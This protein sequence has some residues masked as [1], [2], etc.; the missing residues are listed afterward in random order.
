MFNI[1]SG[2]SLMARDGPERSLTQTSANE[3]TTLNNGVPPSGGSVFTWAPPHSVPVAKDPV[4]STQEKKAPIGITVGDSCEIQTKTVI[5]K[6]D[7]SVKNTSERQEEATTALHVSKKQ[8]GCYY[9]PAE[10]TTS[11]KVEISGEKYFQ[12]SSFGN[13]Q[14]NAN[15]RRSDSDDATI[16]SDFGEKRTKTK[17]VQ[18]TLCH[19]LSADKKQSGFKTQETLGPAN[20][21]SEKSD[22]ECL[23][24]QPKEGLNAEH[25]ELDPMATSKESTISSSSAENKRVEEYK[26]VSFNSLFRR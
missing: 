3:T 11:K 10:S 6:T 5:S 19:I 16:N 7:K 21:E 24:I 4:I 8:Q 9:E 22:H 18:A 25:C 1:E 15:K 14:L 2:T 17:P 20:F 23:C 12:E 26:A 13:I